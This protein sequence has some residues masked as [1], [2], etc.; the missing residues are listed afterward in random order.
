[1]GAGERQAN[2]CH[3]KGERNPAAEAGAESKRAQGV[4]EAGTERSSIP[5]TYFVI[6][7]I[8]EI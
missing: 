8:M 6:S 1:V 3:E 7:A 5:L 2:A 4:T